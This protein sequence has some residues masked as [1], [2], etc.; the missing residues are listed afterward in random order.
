MYVI[1]PRTGEEIY[2]SLWCRLKYFINDFSCLPEIGKDEAVTSHSLIHGEMN[3][4]PITVVTLTMTQSSV[5]GISFIT[6]SNGMW[7]AANTFKPRATC[8]AISFSAKQDK[9]FF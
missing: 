1:R 6:L 5:I 2:L 4:I 9:S 8:R 3:G 7:Y